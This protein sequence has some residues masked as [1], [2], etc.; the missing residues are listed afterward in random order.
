MTETQSTLSE[1]IRER[2][3]AIMTNPLR[4]PHI[5][6]EIC[7]G[8]ISSRYTRCYRCNEDALRARV[9]VA[10]RVVPLTYAVVGTQADRD[11]Y[12]YKDP[13]PPDQRLRNPSYQR[14][15]LLLLGF[16]RT[17]AA[18]LDV[19]APESVTGF[20][21]VPSLKGRPGAHPLAS[22]AAVLPR[23][24]TQ[25]KLDAAPDVPE[26]QRRDLRP[27]HF[28][29]PDSGT[30]AGRHIVVLEDTWVQGG[31]AQSA[32]AAL[33]LA[34]ASDVTILV[35]ARRIRP[36]L[37]RSLAEGSLRQILTEREYSLSVCPVN[38]AS[39]RSSIGQTHDRT[40]R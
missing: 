33:L 15:L 8:P 31:H 4:I 36:D 38:G 26:E 16:S 11:M 27:E 10:Q 30:V 22:L 29:V 23:H 13:M 35:I 37:Q 3:G 19:T 14:L 2:L 18:C 9:P 20:T 28:T 34:G 25:V 1:V 32:A 12:R 5:T 24:W 7:T 6:C 17:H 21:T 40:S 39:C